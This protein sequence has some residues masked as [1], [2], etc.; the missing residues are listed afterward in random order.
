MDYKIFENGEHINT[1]FADEAFVI[2]YCTQFGYTYEVVPEPVPEPDP[3]A[4]PTI[5]DILN[6]M[7]GV[8]RYE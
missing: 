7:L 4:E 6:A 8:S 3:S 1:I 5:E 2:A